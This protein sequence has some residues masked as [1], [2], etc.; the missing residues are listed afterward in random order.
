MARFSYRR[1][2]VAAVALVV[3]TLI[4]AAGGVARGG[5]TPV[6]QHPPPHEPGQE[7]ILE[8]VYGGDFH[9]DGLNFTNGAI[10]LSRIDDADDS[11][12]SQSVGSVRPLANFA[13]R[14][15]ASGFF[16]DADGSTKRLFSVTGSKFDVSGG[17]AAP[18]IKLNGG[19][20]IGRSE[21]VRRAFSSLASENRDHLDH[22]VSYRLSGPEIQ[23]PAY[24]LFWEDKLGPKS[25]FDFNDLVVEVAAKS[26]PL[27]IPLPPAA[28]SGLV[29]M[30]LVGMIGGYRRAR[31]WIC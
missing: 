3:A 23:N 7:Q 11:T 1:L 26:D 24:V 4:G 8:H 15:Q 21:N 18:G 17:A 31:R 13:K 10:T 5:F 2:Q 28:W 22:L 19:I 25:D 29:G 16:E 27:M 6:N 9:A 30:A 12:W 14:Q 20:K